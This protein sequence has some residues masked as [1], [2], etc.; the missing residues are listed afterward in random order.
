MLEVGVAAEGDWVYT[1]EIE[2]VST[3]YVVLGGGKEAHH[4]HRHA[5]LRL[6]LEVDG[7]EAGDGGH[8]AA[9]LFVRI[10]DIGSR[11]ERLSR[12]SEWVFGC[13]VWRVVVE[14]RVR[15]LPM[16]LCAVIFFL[17][18]PGNGAKKSRKQPLSAF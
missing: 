4:L 15:N 2:M 14:R 7:L 16:P 13:E 10:E 8:D 11:E 5:L 12:G 18:A 9:V 1:I 3:T 17:G 6:R